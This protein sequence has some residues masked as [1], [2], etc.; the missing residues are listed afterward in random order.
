MYAKGD[1]AVSLRRLRALGDIAAATPDPQ[2][3]RILIETGKRVVAGCAE[4]LNEEELRGL[5][6]R[7]TDLET[8]ITGV[9]E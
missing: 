6:A 2:L 8:W 4:R 7:L 1:V 9:P 3:R 5:R